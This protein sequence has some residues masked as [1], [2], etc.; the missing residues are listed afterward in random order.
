MLGRVWYSQH[1]GGDNSRAQGPEGGGIT[2][3]HSLQPQH[4][5]CRSSP[6]EL[7]MSA[8]QRHHPSSCCSDAGW[9]LRHC[10]H[11]TLHGGR[12]Q[13]QN[14]RIRLYPIKFRPMAPPMGSFHVTAPRGCLHQFREPSIKRFMHAQT[15]LCISGK[16]RWGVNI[17]LV[18]LWHLSPHNPPPIASLRRNNAFFMLI[19]HTCH[20]RPFS[21]AILDSIGTGPGR[22]V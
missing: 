1:Q 12:Y 11:P 10:I 21:H 7:R 16:L 17:R 13:M 4:F 18:V 9:V 20:F 3:A 8:V 15:H 14:W 6:G 22:I 5:T 2:M 19:K